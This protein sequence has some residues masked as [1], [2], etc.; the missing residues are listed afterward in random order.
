MND[1]KK[2]LLKNGKKAAV[3]TLCTIFMGFCLFVVG[4]ERYETQVNGDNTTQ[5]TENLQYVKTE[6]GGCNLIG[7]MSRG[8]SER[9]NDTVIITISED[10]V[11]I[12]VGLNYI[13]K[14]DAFKTNIEIIDDVICLHL[15]DTGGG[16]NRCMCYYTFDF[17][18]KRQGNINQKYKIL[19]FDQRTGNEVIFSEGTIVEKMLN[20]QSNY[21]KD[22]T[23]SPCK[24]KIATADSVFITYKDK[25]LYIKHKDIYLNCGFEKIDVTT[26]I[27]GNTIL[28]N[29]EERP[30][31]ANC[32]CPVDVSYSIGEL[33]RGKY[34]LTIKH[35]NSKQIYSQTIN[36]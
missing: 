6:L 13:C 9:G 16:Y 25:L 24:E 19:L 12:F 1:T 17:V 11:H 35:H 33:E 8:G 18:F 20:N 28:V 15:I 32:L 36:F 10:S 2:N 14:T 7:D 31:N 21:A 30:T 34:I 5:N 27:N 29:I 23:F 3:E 22:V 26:S 4:C